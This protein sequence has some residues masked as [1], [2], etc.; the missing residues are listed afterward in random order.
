MARPKDQAARREQL[1]SATMRIIATHGLA[2]T[3][4]K[5]IAAEVGIS[6]RLVA[7]YYPDL[8][9]LI[10]AAHES[11]T[12]RYYWARRR[13]IEDEPDP[14]VRLGYLMYSGLP[15]G[16]D[17]MLSRVLDEIS[18]SASRSALHADLMTSLFDREVSLYREVLDA[19]EAAGAFSLTDDADVIACNF[20]TLE[21][22]LGLHLLACTAA[23]TLERAERQL[24]S[25]ARSATGAQVAPAPRDREFDAASIS[26]I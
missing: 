3:T 4:M 22:S 19:G 12:D 11:A 14:A 16:S 26:S 8:E 13:D 5:S 15:R 10:G 9:V 6:A 2:K 7:Y 25:Y 17:Q 21:D 1:I 20:V 23:M 18:V 24:S